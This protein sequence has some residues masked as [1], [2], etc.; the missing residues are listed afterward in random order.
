MKQDENW[1]RKKEYGRTPQYL[2]EIKNNI[3]SEYTMI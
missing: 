3:C 1:M 2:T